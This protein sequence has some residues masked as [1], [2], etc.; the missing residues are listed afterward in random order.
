MACVLVALAVG[1]GALVL[2]SGHHPSGLHR[3]FTARVADAL[4]ERLAGEMPTAQA[5]APADEL[6]GNKL[7]AALTALPEDDRGNTLLLAAR[8]RM[9]TWRTAFTPSDSGRERVC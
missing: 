1:A 6:P 8:D 2:L 3:P 4:L 7:Q 9:K 5:T